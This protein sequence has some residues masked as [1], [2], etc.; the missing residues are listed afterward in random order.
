MTNFWCW[1]KA[2][3]EGLQSLAAL[4][5]LI[6]TVVTIVVLIVTWKAIK[7]Q[8]EAA[9]ALTAVAKDQADAAKK[10]TEVAEQQRIFSERAALA[11][12]KQV[13]AAIASSAVADAQR[14][15]TEDAARAERV[16]S[17]LTRHQILARL[18]PVL[19]FGNKPHPTMGGSTITFVE[20]HGEGI[21]LNIRVQIVQRTKELWKDVHVGV[22]VLGPNKNTEFTYDHRNTVDGRIQVRYDSLDGR[23]FVTTATVTGL[24]FMEQKPFEVDE[25]GGWTPDEAVPDIDSPEDSTA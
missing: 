13:E 5:G 25:K 10:Q 21:A 18:R 20:N 7:A 4:V 2:N 1:L 17:E 23:H 14:K 15:A 12:E 19:V 16:H 11:S 24:S 22:N 3:S 9:T 8:A 6:L